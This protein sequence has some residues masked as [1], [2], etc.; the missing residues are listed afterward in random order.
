MIEGVKIKPLKVIP[1][2]RGR[3]MEI[4][5]SDEELFLGFGQVYL[6]T[7]YPGVVKAWHYHKKQAD[8]FACLRG[9]LKVALYDR[10]EGSPTA[11]EVNTFYLG[12][13][14]PMLLQIPPMV[15]HG[16][17]NIGTEEAILLN[18]PTRP[19]N[20]EE[21]DEYRVPPHDNDIPYDWRAG[22]DG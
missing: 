16:F 7:A 21:P 20:R 1:D 4:L 18:C 22:R 2:D 19:Y 10:R 9:M 17:M 5:R 11:G 8:N 6:T 14:H 13:H 12:D 3:L 15:W